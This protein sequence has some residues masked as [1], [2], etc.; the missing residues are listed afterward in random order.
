[1]HE[2]LQGLAGTEQ[3]RRVRN[4]R[5]HN[6]GTLESE[7]WNWASARST[8]TRGLS[9]VGGWLGTPTGKSNLSTWDAEAG[10]LPV[11]EPAGRSETGRSEP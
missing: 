8:R 9:G 2:A 11:P 6:P 7:A 3:S 10:R 1:M 4:G 5:A